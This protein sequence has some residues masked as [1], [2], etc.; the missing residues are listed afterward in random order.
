MSKRAFLLQDSVLG[1]PKKSGCGTR[2]RKMERSTDER[3]NDVYRF[4]YTVQPLEVMSTRRR[5]QGIFSEREGVNLAEELI[6]STSSDPTVRISVLTSVGCLGGSRTTDPGHV[7]ELF[8]KPG[9][10]TH[11][12][13]EHVVYPFRSQNVVNLHTSKM[14]TKISLLCTLTC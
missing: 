10:V 5:M 1:S 9:A 3:S 13:T 4:R 6:F 7:L 8:R 12:R 2:A 14:S 11:A